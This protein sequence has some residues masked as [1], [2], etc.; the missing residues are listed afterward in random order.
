MNGRVEVALVVVIVYAMSWLV[1]GEGRPRG[2]GPSRGV[3][4]E[5]AVCMPFHGEVCSDRW[6]GRV[7]GAVCNFGIP[8]VR[9]SITL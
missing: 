6:W 5:R 3:T 4:D 8:R 1:K 2:G 7:V 9:C